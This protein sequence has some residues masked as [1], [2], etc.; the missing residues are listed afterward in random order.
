[1]AANCLVVPFAMLGLAGVTA[2]ETSVAAV[3]VSVVD[4]DMLPDAA[5]IVVKPAA[6][7]VATP[8]EPAELLIV[9]TPVLEELQ[10]T[11]GV[12]FWVE[13]SE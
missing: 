10:V 4:P 2:R 1:M 9:A 12:R 6:T 5:V 3:T 8:L 13:L 7:G 11:D